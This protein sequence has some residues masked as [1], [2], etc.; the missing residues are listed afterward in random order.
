[1]SFAQPAETIRSI[2]NGTL[3]FLEAIRLLTRDIRFYNSCSSE[4][5][6]NTEQPADE[7]TV[8]RLRSPRETR[9]GQRVAGHV[10]RALAALP[11]PWRGRCA[12]G[13]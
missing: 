10:L 13:P 12:P 7:L 6:G 11:A 8:F 3:N 9:Q 4:N 1:M 2:V 5:F